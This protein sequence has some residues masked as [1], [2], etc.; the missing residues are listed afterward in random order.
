VTSIPNRLCPDTDNKATD[1][2]EPLLDV[3]LAATYAVSPAPGREVAGV[4]K[5]ESDHQLPRLPQLE[6]TAPLKYNGVCS[7]ELLLEFS[8]EE[9]LDTDVGEDDEDKDEEDDDSEVQT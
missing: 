9:L 4:V 3:T 8:A 7:A 1:G 6:S 2:C 5:D